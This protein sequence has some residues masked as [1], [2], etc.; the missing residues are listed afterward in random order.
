MISRICAFL[1]KAKNEQGFTLVEL[2]MVVA[3]IGLLAGFGIPS[4]RNARAKAQE[5]QVKAAVA[6]VVTALEMY[7][8][9]EGSYPASLNDLVGT[10]IQ[11]LD[12]SLLDDE[13]PSH[14]K[15]KPVGEENNYDDYS[16]EVYINGT[17][18]TELGVD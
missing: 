17:L 4:Y 16:L 7:M 11:N 12:P 6:N 18:N 1:R 13:S 10:Y 3:V 14:I 2:M 8:A 15:Y 5:A 9:E